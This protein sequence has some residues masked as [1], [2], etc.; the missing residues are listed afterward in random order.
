[1]RKN[2]I[3]MGVSG[4]GKST[5][6]QMVAD[7][8]NIEFID[9]DDYHP[10]SNK[11]KMANGQPL[12]DDDRLPWLEILHQQLIRKVPVVLGC[13]ALKASYRQLLDPE[14]AFHWI[15]LNGPRE[16]ILKRMKQRAHFMKPDMLDSQLETLEVPKTA[17]EISIDATPKEILK[18][19]TTV[20]DAK[21]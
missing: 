1:M 5:I 15:Y 6:G 13:S 9:A 16:L 4:S 18:E 3:V 20:I 12:N 11:Q 7:R 17:H 19:I 2:I 14:M 8:Y 10:E 21:V